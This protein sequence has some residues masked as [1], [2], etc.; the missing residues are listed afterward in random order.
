MFPHV[1]SAH[2]AVIVLA[3]A[4]MLMS[5]IEPED[6]LAARLVARLLQALPLHL[7]ILPSARCPSADCSSQ[8]RNKFVPFEVRDG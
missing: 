2:T 4:T 7:E 8:A 3:V 6:G 1:F 5:S